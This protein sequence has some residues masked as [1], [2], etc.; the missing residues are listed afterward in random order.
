MI[1]SRFIFWLFWASLSTP[2]PAQQGDIVFPPGSGVLNVVTDAG[3]DNTGRSDVTAALQ[4]IVAETSL[5]VIYFPKGTY[6]ISGQLRAKLDPSRRPSSHSHGP[7][8]V[9]EN[10]DET[11]IRL[12]DGTWTKPVNSLE[13]NE[14]GQPDARV[15]EQCVLSS[16]DCTNTTFN[17]VFRNFT[18]NIGKNNA[19]AVGLMYNT[20][21]TGY[22]GE[23]NIVSEDGQG[24][25]GLALAGVE[26]GPGQVRNVKIRGFDLGMYNVAHYVIA[27]SNITIENPN[28]LALYNQGMTT[29][30][31]FEITMA[32]ADGPAIRNL[33]NA[34]LNLLNSSIRASARSNSPAIENENGFLW[35]R[36]LETAGFA[37]AVTGTA[38]A[39]V[40]EFFTGKGTGLFNDTKKSLRLPIKP[41]PFVAFEKDFSKWTNPM[42]C[43]AVGNGKADDS[44]AVQKALNSPGK[45]HVVF[46]SDKQFRVAKPLTIGPAIVRLIGTHGRML[47]DVDSGAK[48]TISEGS[49]PLMIEGF[50]RCP[51]ISVKSGRTV[52]LSAVNPGVD[53]PPG[54]GLASKYFAASLILEG[55][56]DVFVNNSHGT[57]E[58]NNPAQKVWVRHYNSELG[59]ESRNEFPAVHVKAGTL[60]MLGWKSENLMRRAIVEKAGAMELI[61]FNNYEVSNKLKKDG[62]WPIFEVLD[63]QF[64]VASLIQEGSQKNANLVWESRNG[65]KRILNEQSN[66]GK[67][68]GLYTGYDSTRVAALREKP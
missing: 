61:G 4:K 20:S 64:S 3:V 46:P 12:K 26:N 13:V 32:R 22:L 8:I 6:L 66:G 48:M 59:Q 50:S 34:S 24:L 36:N 40:D 1:R 35:L 55:T 57:M 43:G 9:G 38:D 37:S 62:E 27:C 2:L 28:K 21:N 68:L 39:R 31:N 51:R 7:W 63:G 42:D 25:C 53:R 44:E 67:N 45:T 16:G 30:E 23:V 10:R 41:Q 49:A 52:I 5:R 47:W 18:V 54:K 56:G 19:G 58:V 15:Y 11:I 29:G 14:K 17:K 65:E 60:W 33:K